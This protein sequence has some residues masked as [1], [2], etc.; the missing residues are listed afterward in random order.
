MLASR[1]PEPRQRERLSDGVSARSEERP[2]G[3]GLDLRHR[4]RDARKWRNEAQGAQDAP[5]QEL[6][7]CC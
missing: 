2:G 7:R 4:P 1:R 3:V 5:E 6:A